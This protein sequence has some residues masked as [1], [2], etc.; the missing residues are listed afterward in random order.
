MIELPEHLRKYLAEAVIAR[1]QMMAQGKLLGTPLHDEL[2][3]AARERYNFAA[4][5]VVLG[6]QA[7][8]INQ[9][10]SSNHAAT[11]RTLS[12]LMR[13]ALLLL[14]GSSYSVHVLADEGIH[15]ETL[16]ALMRRGLLTTYE[17]LPSPGNDY[18]GST[19]YAITDLGRSVVA[20]I[21]DKSA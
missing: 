12:P 20:H 11:V 7:E 18:G 17:K 4:D 8:L 2:Y 9:E 1:E 14:Q 19:Y 5:M 10:R 16:A 21:K 13:A 6:L 15:S 3:D